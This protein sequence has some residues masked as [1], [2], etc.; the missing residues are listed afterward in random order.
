MESAPATSISGGKVVLASQAV[1][2]NVSLLRHKTTYRKPY[3]DPLRD[4]QARDPG[5]VDVILWDAA[6]YV[7]ESGMANVIVRSGADFYTPSLQQNFLPGV[8]RRCLLEQ[9]IVKE[10]A[11]LPTSSTS[12]APFF[13][14]IQCGV[15]CRWIRWA[16]A[17]GSSVAISSTRRRCRR[18]ARPAADS[19]GSAE[20]GLPV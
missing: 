11:I 10:G 12:R 13:W 1:P 6:G 17:S 18:L 2:Q 19:A 7:T 3:S 16:A 9:G 14:S 20:C 5:I 15:G 4:Q 8:F